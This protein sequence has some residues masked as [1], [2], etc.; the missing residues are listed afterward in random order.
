MC[1]SFTSGI[2]M[3]IQ[4]LRSWS[5]IRAHIG[6]PPC[7][8]SGNVRVTRP[9]TGIWPNSTGFLHVSLRKHSGNVRW[10]S[11]FLRKTSGRIR[12]PPE[13]TRRRPYTREIIRFQRDFPSF[14][15]LPEGFLKETFRK[16]PDDVRFP[17]ENVRTYDISSGNVRSFA[18]LPEI[19]TFSYGKAP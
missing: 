15:L 17:P 2:L 10:N 8:P 14:P 1:C 4:D 3:R 18:G 9:T 16:R 5:Q 12:F 7:F 19:T 6:V 13:N 11:V